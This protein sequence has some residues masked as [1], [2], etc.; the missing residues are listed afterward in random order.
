V[1]VTVGLL[2]AG[3]W[4]WNG[5]RNSS[6]SSPP[7]DRPSRG[8]ELVAT[9][10][11]EPRSFNR[12]AVRTASAELLSLLVQSRLVRVNRVTNEVE[13]WLAERWESS[14][15]GLV[16][17]LH[18][19]PELAW[20]DGTPFTAADVAFSAQVATDARVSAIATSLRVADQPIAATAVDDRTVRVTYAG[21][22]GPGIRLLDALPIVPRH[23]LEASYKDDTFKDAWSMQTAPGDV[24]G[25]GPFVFTSY[26]PGQRVVLSRNPHY[27]R[28]DPEGQQLPYVDRIVL[29]VVPDQNAELLRL[30]AGASDLL[31]DEIRSEDYV[32]V[33]RAEEQGSLK[34]VELGVSTAVDGLW[35][36]LKPAA[37]RGDPKFAFVQRAEFR[38]ALSHAVDRDA[39]SETVF[40]GAAVPVWGPVTPGNREWFSPNIP[41]YPFDRSR[42]TALLQGLGLADRNGDGVVEDAKG[43][44]ARL[45]VIT[46]RGLGW[47]ERGLAFLKEQAAQIGIALDVVPL[48]FG[49]MMQRVLACDFDTVYMRVL[50]TDLDPA[51]NL[52]FWLSSG[53]A[54]LWSLEQKA[55]DT[56][57]EAQLDAI[58]RRQAS[59]LD[60][61]ARRATFEEAQQLFAKHLPAIYFAAPR[62]Y[63]AHAARLR[64]VQ[65]SVQR[66]PVLWNAD[67]LSLAGDRVAR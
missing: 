32:P 60:P 13:P 58:M 5:G 48:E 9:V 16:H 46:Q 25:L 26:E 54:R 63:T 6:L 55:P 7:I 23:K 56:E 36:C 1:I 43:T 66:P 53:S 51:A 17:T 42:A 67:S 41:R 61:A 52:D 34:L 30:Q 10:R 24:V 50:S 4:F 38:Q 27:W 39:F 21:P 28:R 2:A 49:A 19:R 22:F 65:P 40:L 47:N 59:T 57:W 8:G 35:F 64:G 3:Y 62:T 44:P 29:E 15:D 12:I 33:R 20:S 37:K 31:Q 14:A 45:T 18:L 11:T